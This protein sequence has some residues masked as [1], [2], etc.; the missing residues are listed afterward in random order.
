M[1]PWGRA[2]VGV[3]ENGF[4]PQIG[5]LGAPPRSWD[6][7][8]VLRAF[9]KPQGQEQGLSWNSIPECVSSDRS[10]RGPQAFVAWRRL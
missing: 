9:L 4:H 6:W 1:E 7:G 2:V 10:Y 5:R 8:L 3:E